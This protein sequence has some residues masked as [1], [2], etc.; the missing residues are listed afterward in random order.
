MDAFETSQLEAERAASGGLYLEFLRRDSMS[1]GLY[2][3][4]AGAE[5]PQTPHDEDEAYVVVAGRGAIMVAGENQECR[6]GVGRVRRPRRRA[7]V[8]L[9][10]RAAADPGGLRA[11]RVRVAQPGVARRHDSA[12]SRADV[13]RFAHARR[14]PWH[15]ARHHARH[16]ARHP[17]V[18]WLLAPPGSA[19]RYTRPSDEPQDPSGGGQAWPRRARSRRQDHR[20]HAPRRRH[21]G[22]LHG[23]PPDTRADRRDRDP[24]GRR[25]RRHLDPVRRAHDARAADPRP[26]EGERRGR[27]ARRRGRHHP[28]RR[29]RRAEGA[30]RRRGV[31]AGR[32][33][34][35]IVD[36]LRSKLDAA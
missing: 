22:H 24:G 1:L 14:W 36:F 20:A 31:H 9:D 8:P 26:A 3:L 11:A 17:R 21:G 6:P 16:R 15:C 12:R 28:H 18:A 23:T 29:H 4:D 27:R 7:P 35:Q 33:T 10:H 34:A 13:R 19:D 5:D 2:T 25:R 30:G 32:P